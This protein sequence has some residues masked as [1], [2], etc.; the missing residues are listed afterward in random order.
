MIKCQNK[1]DLWFFIGK[2]FGF[3]RS[4]EI[5]VQ[6]HLRSRILQRQTSK[7]NET[8]S[9]AP[10]LDSSQSPLVLSHQRDQHHSMPHDMK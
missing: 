3:Q 10:P 4:E 2:R 8:P 1:N 6:P 7:E 9:S 5:G